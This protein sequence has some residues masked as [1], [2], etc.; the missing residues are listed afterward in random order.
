M[1]DRW[2][3]DKFM[4]P[5]RTESKW[6]KVSL[7][8]SNCCKRESVRW[9][10]ILKGLFSF[11]G[12]CNQYVD[13]IFIRNIA[14][15]VALP[16]LFI[17]AQLIDVFY[18]PKYANKILSLL[19]GVYFGCEAIN[20]QPVF[21]YQ[22]FLLKEYECAQQR[23]K[24]VTKSHMVQPGLWLTK[25]NLETRAGNI[26]RYRHTGMLQEQTAEQT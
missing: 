7:K 16:Q 17:L 26:L 15:R 22:K 24:S 20:E 4:E 2:R 10:T 21:A 23:A 5:C 6:C 11:K 1:L 8:F 13:R 25:I 19:R 18:A 14:R 9:E 3:R 12:F